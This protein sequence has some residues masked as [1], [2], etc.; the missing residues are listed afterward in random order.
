MRKQTLAKNGKAPAAIKGKPV[1]KAKG[2]RPSAL[3]DRVVAFVTKYLACTPEQADVIALFV[4]H[5]YC[6]G[7]AEATPYLTVTAPEKASGKT[8]LLEVLDAVVARPWFTGRVTTA[9]LVRKVSSESPTLLLDESDAAFRSNKEYAE[10]LRGVLNA[11]YRVGGK[12]SLTVRRG[13]NWESADFSTFCPKVI[14]G[15][16]SLP[17]T[18]ASRAIPI[19]LKRLAPGETVERFYRRD[20]DAE[21]KPLRDELSTWSERNLSTLQGA[22]PEK[23]DELSERT[24]DVWEPL[25]AIADAVGEDWP[26]R[27]RRAA[28]VLSGSSDPRDDSLGVQLLADIRIVFVNWLKGRLS[29]ASLV[30][31]LRLLDESPWAEWNYRGLTAHSL[32]RLLRP[33]DIEPTAWNTT[34]GYARGYLRSQ[35]SDA[36]MRYLKPV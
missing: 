7:A 9:A 33:Y 12:T 3:L 31:K 15:I 16:G 17:D 36:F 6:F 4:V 5:T 2:V 1:A 35:F 14:A 20:A 13:D 11:G 24:F 26:E 28:R 30:E 8:R 34:D 19:G 10:A 29:S 25:L 18:I 22:R 23:L 27:A 21:A 32:A